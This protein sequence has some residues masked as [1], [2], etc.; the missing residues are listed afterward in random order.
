M[1][2]KLSWTELRRL[3][4]RRAGVSEKSA[5]AF[6]NS[7]NTQIVE[8]LKRDKQVKVNGLGTFKLQAVSPRKSVNVT[9]GEDITIAGYNKIAF[10]SEAGVKELVEK[11]STISGQPS[12]ANT[13]DPLQKLSAQAEEI[14]DLLG[15][16]GQSP[17][18]PEEQKEEP[19]KEPSVVNI[20]PSEEAVE[21]PK[22]ES[23]VPETPASPE[24]PKRPKRPAKRKEAAAEP[25]KTVEP[26]AEPKEEPVVETVVEPAPEP[27]AEPIAEPIAEPEMPAEPVQPEKPKKKRH[28]WRD[29]LICVVILL[30]ILV[31]AF[32]FFRDKISDMI[33]SMVE[34]NTQELV[35]KEQPNAPSAINMQ[36]SEEA[37]EEPVKEP[38]A[39]SIQPSEEAVEEPAEAEEIIYTQWMKTETITKGSRLA[40]I[41]KK[42]YGAKVYWPYLYDA[43][44]DHLD[45]PNMI[46]IGTPIRVPKLTKLQ[47]DTTNAQT[48]AAIE[49]LRIEA[50][51]KMR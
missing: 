30:M 37:V 38:S 33:H 17:N 43:N 48:M 47:R 51:R 24:K 42:Y 29:T 4:A 26:V 6:L 31:I 32:F 11:N 15:D 27:V 7:L 23:A 20:Q 18:K 44:N 2:D 12:D 8:A 14:V 28:F 45:N 50:E 49:R 1:A 19:V 16:L 13:I 36:P 10:S 9:T 35:V 3:I 21:E 22:E 46:K 5:N 39:V 41:A 25:E 34:E 40:W